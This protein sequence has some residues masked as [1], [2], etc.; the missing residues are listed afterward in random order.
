LIGYIHCCRS[1][2]DV[3]QPLQTDF[4]NLSILGCAT[5]LPNSI[6]ELVISLTLTS[7]SVVSF[8]TAIP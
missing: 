4:L 6:S 8:S 2:L 7:P 1:L 5:P 3:F